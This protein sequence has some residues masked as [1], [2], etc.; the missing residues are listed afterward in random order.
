MTIADALREKASINRRLKVLQKRVMANSC[1]TRDGK[2]LEQPQPMLDEAAI[3][4]PRLH[5]LSSVIEHANYRCKVDD[6]PL[7]PPPQPLPLPT[8]SYLPA[9]AAAESAAASSAGAIASPSLPQ[10]CLLDLILEHD[11]MAIVGGWTR[12][13]T[14][15]VADLH[16]NDNNN[17]NNVDVLVPYT[18]FLRHQKVLEHQRQTLGTRIDYLNSCTYVSWPATK[19]NSP[20]HPLAHNI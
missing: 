12:K 7:L 13:I 11:A 2:P 15:A 5:L 4:L 17:N 16:N 14:D 18:D 9:S 3:L 1:V 19:P 10:R 8:E 20:P 6:Q